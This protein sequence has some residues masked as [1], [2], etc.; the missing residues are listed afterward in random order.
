MEKKTSDKDQQTLKLTAEERV[1]RAKV[2][3][4]AQH[5]RARRAL[6]GF[7]KNAGS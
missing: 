3:K 2:E 6:T 5:E 7:P 1:E 4:K